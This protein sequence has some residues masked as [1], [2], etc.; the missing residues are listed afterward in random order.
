MA[1]ESS[2][3]G[4]PS[5]WVV[6]WRASSSRARAC[7]FAGLPAQA[8]YDAMFKPFV[9]RFASEAA[10][11]LAKLPKAKL[12]AAAR[13]YQ[14][15]AKKGGKSFYGPDYLQSNFKKIL[16]DDAPADLGNGRTL[17]I[18]LRR[19]LDGTWPTVTKLLKRVLQ[20]YDPALYKDLGSKL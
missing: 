13:D 9:S 4:R 1:P 14:D 16:G 6:K 17:G 5:G 3:P 20:D 11:V 2:L 7:A 8:Y 12:A 18:V 19:Q 15:A 10:L